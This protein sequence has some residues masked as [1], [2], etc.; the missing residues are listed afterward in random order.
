MKETL[1][2]GKVVEKARRDENLLLNIKYLKDRLKFAKENSMYPELKD[3]FSLLAFTLDHIQ[4]HV[5]DRLVCDQCGKSCMA[6]NY[7]MRNLEVTAITC[8]SCAHGDY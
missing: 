3:S 5:R 7:E 2:R 1:Y 4:R 6:R 8:F